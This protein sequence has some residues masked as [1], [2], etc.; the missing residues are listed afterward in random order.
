MTHTHTHTHSADT[1]PYEITMTT[2]TTPPINKVYQMKSSYA[3]AIGDG[4]IDNALHF[5]SFAIKL[6]Y[7][8]AVMWMAILRR[9]ENER[10]SE[11]QTERERLKV[12]ERHSF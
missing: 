9:Q 7:E 6:Q 12:R 10:K 1:Y 5:V 4:G 11:R 2:A 3:F 8:Y